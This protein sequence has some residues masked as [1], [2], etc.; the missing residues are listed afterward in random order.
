MRRIILA[1]G[2]A[3]ALSLG[4]GAEY[5][6]HPFTEDKTMHADNSKWKYFFELPRHVGI[7]GDGSLQLD[8]EASPAVAGLSANLT[9]YLNGVPLASR[10]LAGE[11]E[12]PG[13][14]RVVLPRKYFKEGFNELDLANQSKTTEGPC[15]E[16]DDLRNW[17]RYLSTSILRINLDSKAMYPLA[18]YPFPYVNWLSQT[19]TS[20]PILI[21]RSADEK[22]V[23]SAL[24]F[25]AG[26]GARF[27]DKPLEVLL[28]RG[29]ST[30]L[31]VHLG[32]EKELS[33]SPP[34]S[35]IEV[36]P[37][38]LWISGDNAEKLDAAVRTVSN[39]EITAQM[40]GYASSAIDY[41]V[42]PGRPSTRLGS[43]TFYE[44]GLT[45]VYLAGL[46]N[47][48]TSIV[49]RRPLVA[50]LGREGALVIR[51]RHSAT[52]WRSKSLLSVTVNDHPISNV[53]LTPENANDGEL[54]CPMP[55]EVVNSNEWRIQITSHNEVSNPDCS[56]AYEDVAWTAILGSSSFQLK[57]GKLPSTP[58]LDGFPYFRGAAGIL[59]E[60]VTL[61][62]ATNPSDEELTL[63]S[64][65]AAHASQMNRESV[66][67]RSSTGA[68]TG[69]EDVLIGRLDDEERFRS[70]SANLLVT[71]SKSGPP[72]IDRS[73]PLLPSSLDDA[74]VI[75][76]VRK[77]SGGVAY[78]V[79]GSSASALDRFAKYIA[80]LKGYDALHGQVAVLTRDGELLTFE[81]VSAAEKAAAEDE[82]MNRYRPSMTVIMTAIGALFVLLVIFIGSKFIKR[83][84]VKT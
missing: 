31:A 6:V 83:K 77:Q 55:I 67:W 33:P 35:A 42:K 34:K 58:Y 56:K 78:V 25:A 44:L 23:S 2:V 1:F 47:Q 41:L 12:A 63:A 39:P 62:L 26:L 4:F 54:A 21:S 10:S 27:I 65:I 37:D 40:S 3:M 14:W 16:D 18:S 5:P 24:N 11:N 66:H 20:V 49:I 29:A 51:F 84:G 38:G 50:Q 46:G 15:R 22:T 69:Q 71:P 30:S 59:P 61:S 9:V 48:T 80:S 36:R 28:S 75:E 72:R 70:I 13:H 45:T 76:A 32:L 73:L 53:A 79:L 81:T 7:S 64:T 8:F 43:T 17:V 60:Y 57:D 19:A 82:E 52:L 68:I 74:T